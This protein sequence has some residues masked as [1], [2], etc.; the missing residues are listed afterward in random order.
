MDLLNIKNAKD[1]IELDFELN[2]S[3]EEIGCNIDESS[4]YEE[5]RDWFAQDN[6]D[7]DDRAVKILDA[8]IAR[9]H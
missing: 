8:A 3:L 1:T 7:A 4:S 5:S 2:K 6:E 9:W